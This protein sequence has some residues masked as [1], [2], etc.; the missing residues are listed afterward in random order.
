MDTLQKD[1]NF[2]SIVLLD[3][4]V[5]PYIPAKIRFDQILLHFIWNKRDTWSSR[6]EAKKDL[7]SNPGHRNWHPETMD[8]YIVRC[9]VPLGPPLWLMLVLPAAIWLVR[10]LR[11]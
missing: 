10:P 11:V 9:S 3:P 2:Q 7:I 1:F 5:C 6:A 8:L 4:T